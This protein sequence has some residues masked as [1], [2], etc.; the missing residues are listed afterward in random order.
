MG[1]VATENKAFMTSS[2]S[3]HKPAK[4]VSDT[5]DKIWT[6]EHRSGNSLSP[7]TSVILPDGCIDLIIN[8]GSLNMKIVGLMKTPKLFS[9]VGDEELIGVRFLPG[10][11]RRMFGE[12]AHLTDKVIEASLV[13]EL[14]REVLA[15]P[16][17]L[18]GCENFDSRKNIVESVIGKALT[19]L[20]RRDRSIRSVIKQIWNNKKPLRDLRKEAGISQRQFERIVKEYV[21]APPKTL[22]RISRFQFAKKSLQKGVSAIEV[23]YFAGYSDQAHMIR[24]FKNLSGVTPNCYKKKNIGAAFV[25][26]SF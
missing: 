21:G 11:A 14:G 19:P 10:A 24:E 22:M 16:E 7:T 4:S 8:I 3:E 9:P 5:I 15:L 25:Q 2:Y 6:L 20:T 18:G 12:V 23:A 1:I 17:R 26:S 13:D